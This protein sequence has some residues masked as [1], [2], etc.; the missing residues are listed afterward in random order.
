M[1]QPTEYQI[2]RSFFDSSLAIKYSLKSG[3][4]I[5]HDLVLCTEPVVKTVME[6]V[7]DRLESLEKKLIS[8]ERQ[9]VNTEKLLLAMAKSMGITVDLDAL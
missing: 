5:L 7:E 1:T 9:M 4:S 8:Q 2:I 6:T 3:H